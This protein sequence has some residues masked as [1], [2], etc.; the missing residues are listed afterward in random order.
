VICARAPR[1]TLGIAAA[2]FGESDEGGAKLIVA[3]GNPAVLLELV[4]EALDMVALAIKSPCPPGLPPPMGAVG[5]VRNGALS[6]DM[7][8]DAIRVV[9]FVSD[10]NG[11]LSVK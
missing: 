5:D 8:A 1:W 2:E 6:S 9:S 7:G 3:G 11:T 4:E 10:D